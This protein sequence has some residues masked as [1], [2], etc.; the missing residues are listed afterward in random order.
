MLSGSLS[1][2][3]SVVTP[4][5]CY[6]LQFVTSVVSCSPAELKLD[7]NNG[8]KEKVKGFNVILKDTILFPEGGGQVTINV[9]LHKKVLIVRL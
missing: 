8:K 9:Y 4:C 1:L 2:S 6:F 3:L 5:L 7:S